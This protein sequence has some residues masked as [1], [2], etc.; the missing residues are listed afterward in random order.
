MKKTLTVEE[1]IDLIT[2]VGH[3]I[4]GPVDPLDSDSAHPKWSVV[5]SVEIAFKQ[6]AGEHPKNWTAYIYSLEQIIRQQE[7]DTAF[8]MYWFQHVINSSMR[9]YLPN[10]DGVYV[11]D[12]YGPVFGSPL[13]C[14]GSL[15]AVVAYFTGEEAPNAHF[16]QFFVDASV[17]HKS[18]TFQEFSKKVLQD[19]TDFYNMPNMPYHMR[20]WLRHYIGNVKRVLF[21]QAFNELEA[22]F[23][24]ESESVPVL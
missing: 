24:T 16:T 1:A 22:A 13:F 2:P 7:V 3:N 21:Y 23:E 9:K 14:L 12:S 18:H 5:D 17:P 10:G 15:S 6:I 8:F 11:N 20:H 4:Y 19:L